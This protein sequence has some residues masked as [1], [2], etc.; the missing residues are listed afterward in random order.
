MS[1]MTAL[2]SPLP[3][4][5]E[6]TK[7]FDEYI[8]KWRVRTINWVLKS[9]N[10]PVHV[11]SYEDLTRDRVREVGKILDFLQFP[12]DHNELAERLNKDY[13]FFQRPHANEEEFQHFSPGEKDKLRAAIESLRTSAKTAGMEHMF[14]FDEYL[15][16]LPDIP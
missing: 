5:K 8:Y 6:W 4:T 15:Q 3:G 1:A 2:C 9:G 13:T 7:F 11:V 10:H 14:L 16:S 12:Y